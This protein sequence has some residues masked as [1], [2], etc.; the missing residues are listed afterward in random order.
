MRRNAWCAI[1]AALML[2]AGCAA[3]GGGTAAAVKKPKTHG[4]AA[5][6]PDSA[7]VFFW[8]L[9][10]TTGV[11]IG[12]AGSRGIE[13][14]SGLE[15]RPELGRIHGARGFTRSVDSF[16]HTRYQP[17]LEATSE[18]TIEAWVQISA[19]GQYEDT[20]IAMRWNSRAAETS[21]LFAVGGEHLVPP[22]A[23]LP[24]PGDHEALMPVG[25]NNRGTG[26][27]MFAYQ[28][29]EAGAPRAFFSNATLEIG[30]WT[31]VAATFNGK[32]VC[33]YINGRIDSQFAVSGT[34]RESKADLLVGNA[35]DSRSLTTFGGDLKLGDE[36]D[37]NPYYA[38][39][40]DIDELRLSNIARTEFPYAY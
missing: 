15:T 9:D 18:L 30:R 24:S 17:A 40:G 37:H 13:G 6:E 22:S 21:W 20:P 25:F 35:F 23:T 28:S 12:D 36:Y 10:E 3:G 16:L 1:A 8:R 29:A 4:I 32:T 2:V 19:I 38:F 31:H 7:T 11:R 26:K 27:L 33:L 34:L 5:A 14:R 39:Q